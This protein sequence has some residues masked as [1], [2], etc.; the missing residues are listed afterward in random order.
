MIAKYVLPI[1]VEEEKPY[2]LGV[3]R[4]QCSMN[5]VFLEN[6]QNMNTHFEIFGIFFAI[7]DDAIN[8]FCD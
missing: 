2:R 6:D 1:Q 7:P 3:P 5:E 8:L 4:L